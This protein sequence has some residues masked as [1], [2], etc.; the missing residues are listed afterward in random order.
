MHFDSRIFQ[1]RPVTC[2]FSQVSREIGFARVDV[3]QAVHH[4]PA[5]Q[6][7]DRAAETV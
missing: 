6:A 1:R 5:R 4:A 7:N 3:A 2:M